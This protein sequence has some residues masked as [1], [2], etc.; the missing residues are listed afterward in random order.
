[1]DTL[2]KP[3][4][5]KDFVLWLEY[6]AELLRQGRV[7][8]LDLENLAEEVESIGQRD[9]REAYNRLTV[10]LMHL[11]KYEFQPERRTRS[12]RSTVREQRRQLKL[13]FKDSPSLAKNYVPTVID[14]IY[15]DARTDAV[16][17]TGL[18]LARF[19]ETSPYS[20]EQILDEDFLPEAT[21]G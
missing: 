1:M 4:Y 2:E 12:W 16:D 8:E 11:L 20:L 21:H 19:P 7:A 17:E 10:L 3:T 5:E 13:V 14:D 9:K 18:L 15:Q 6:Q